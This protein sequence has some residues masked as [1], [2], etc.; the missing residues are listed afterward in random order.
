MRPSFTGTTRQGTSLIEALVG[1][2]LILLVALCLALIFRSAVRFVLEANERLDIQQSA[3]LAVANL[4]REMSEGTTGSFEVYANPPGVVF[5]SAR[6]PSGAFHLS[7]GGELVWQKMICYY[8]VNV[9]GVQCLARKELVLPPGQ[10]TSNPVQPG[11]TYSTTVFANDPGPPRVVGRKIKELTVTPG[12]QIQVHLVAET[13]ASPER[14]FW[15]EVD[16][17][18]SMRN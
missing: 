6:D 17:T 15:I 13:N 10:Q 14:N 1:A 7:P 4:S 9:K 11:S 2:S 18:V 16:T 5:G 3:L 8:I 12:A